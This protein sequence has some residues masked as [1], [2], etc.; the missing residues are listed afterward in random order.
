MKTL[1][2]LLALLWIPFSAMSQNHLVHY[3]QYGKYGYKDD[4]GNVIIPA[5]YDFIG[6]FYGRI[7]RVKLNHRWG[8]VDQK[9]NLVTA[10]KYDSADD[11]FRST[12]RAWVLFHGKAGIID[13]TG[14]EVIPTLYDDVGY[15]FNYDVDYIRNG[16][17]YGLI[18]KAGVEIVSPQYDSMTKDHYWRENRIGVMKNGKWGFIDLQG[19]VKVPFKYD[20]VDAFQEGHALVTLNAKMGFINSE[21]VEFV[22]PVYDRATTFHRYA[23]AVQRK[24]K[25]GF[26]NEKGEMFV[27]FIYDDVREFGFNKFAPVRKGGWGMVDT[28]GKVVIPTRFTEVKIVNTDDQENVFVATRLYDKWG[29]MDTKGNIVAEPKYDE[30]YLEYFRIAFKLDGKSG[31]FDKEGKEVWR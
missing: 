5:K 20:A 30:V 10:L 7:T 12:D 16:R 8:F 29:L 11:Y 13:G 4:H 31:Y 17:K 22:P 6:D 21:G 27:D 28:T 14:I 1:P 23:G 24:G 3:K 26:V 19:N 18:S 2:L 15:A 25:W 9:G